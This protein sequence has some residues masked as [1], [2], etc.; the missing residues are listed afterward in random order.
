MAR[1]VRTA[2]E[3]LDEV[4]GVDGQGRWL[5]VVEVPAFKLL[6]FADHHLVRQGFLLLDCLGFR[7]E[8]RLVVGGRCACVR[9][10]CTSKRCR[11][12]DAHVLSAGFSR[13]IAPKRPDHRGHGRSQTSCLRYLLTVLTY[14]GTVTAARQPFGCSK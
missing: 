10:C 12:V 11:H 2:L 5:A 13:G 7:A 9:G 3:A 6:D 8:P 4:G 1:A 14:S